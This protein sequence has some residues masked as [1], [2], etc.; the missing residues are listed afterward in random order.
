MVRPPRARAVRGLA[1]L[2][3]EPAD[4]SERVDQALLGAP[5]TILA[6]RG[7]VSARGIDGSG[8]TQPV[9]RLNG[10]ALPRDADQQA[11]AGWSV[12]A[13]LPGDLFFFGPERVTHSAI[14][15]GPRTFLHAPMQGARVERG[16]PGD[17]LRL[18]AIRRYLP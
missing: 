11:R 6:L 12:D 9:Y 2:Q 5:V 16:E 7:G 8:F 13:A 4:G 1:D 14:A 3:A 10:V 17:A 18:V 15:T